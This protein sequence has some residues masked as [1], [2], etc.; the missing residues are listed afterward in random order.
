MGRQFSFKTTKHTMWMD[1]YLLSM[2]ANQRS[3]FLREAVMAR[4]GVPEAILSTKPMCVFGGTVS[5]NVAQSVPQ[6]A[7]Q[8]VTPNVTQKVTQ[9]PP[10]IVAK[11]VS[12][13]EL[14]DNLDKYL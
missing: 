4:L 7:T 6:K 1:Q 9:R 14:D 5:Q 3:E 13:D 2:P 11:P 8:E 10:V 12:D